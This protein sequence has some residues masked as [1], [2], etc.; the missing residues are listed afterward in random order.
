MFKTFSEY[1]VP[2]VIIDLKSINPFNYTA[3][4]PIVIINL[5][6]VTKLSTS[7]H[8]F[9]V[10]FDIIHVHW[11]EESRY[12]IYIFNLIYSTTNTILHNWRSLRLIQGSFIRRVRIEDHR[13]P[14][15]YPEFLWLEGAKFKSFLNTNSIYFKIYTQILKLV[16]DLLLDNFFFLIPVLSHFGSGDIIFL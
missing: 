15:A 10:I 13:G 8:L 11:T 6:N 4:L 3:P 16:H 14:V 2:N 1:W 5:H 12:K 9:S 7:L